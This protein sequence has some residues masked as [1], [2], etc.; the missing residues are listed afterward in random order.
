MLGPQQLTF[1]VDLAE[2]GGKV[3]D[4]TEG[5]ELTRAKDLLGE[6]TLAEKAAFCSGRDFWHLKGIERLG[7]PSIMLTD[8]PHGLRKQTVSG[9]RVDLNA[10]V[11]TTCFPT[12]AALAATWNP[13]L[14]YRV[15]EALAQECLAEKVAI[16][17]GPGANI[18]R[19]PLCG[20]NFEYFSEDPYLTGEM[21]KA[22]IRGVQSKGIG[23]ALKHY[24]A[25]NQES[26]RMSIDAIV[27]ERALREIY[28]TG[29]EIA[30]RG[31]QPATVMCAY[32][33]VNG[34]YCSEH[35]R[36]L[37]EI[38]RDEWG[39]AGV[40]VSDW[41]AVNQRVKGLAAGL[42][43]EM[44]GSRGQND[45]VLLKAVEAGELDEAVLDRAVER[46]LTL[47]LRL[48]G[49]L[50]EDASYDR[51]AHHAL[52]RQVACEAAVL[53]KNEGGI[54]PLGA[55]GPIALIGAFART[56]RYQGAGSSQI[57]PTR[58]ENL[59]DEL[60]KLVGHEQT[61]GFADG[62]RLRGDTIDHAVLGEACR[63]AAQAAVA[64]VCVGLPDCFEVEGVD[65]AHMRLPQ[66]HDALVEAVAGVNPNVVVVLSNGS[67]VELPWADRVKGILEA[68]LGGQA[69]GGAIADI[70]TGRVNPSGKLAETF[71]LHAQ[72][73]PSYA[74]FP[75]GRKTVEYRESVYVGYRYYDSAQRAV[76]FPFG[77]GLSYTKFQYDNLALSAARIADGDR[78]TVEATVTNVGPVAGKETV[79][80]YVRDVEASVFRPDKELKGFLKI[81]L[82]PGEERRVRF[83]LD[84]RAFAFYDTHSAGWRVEPGEFEV[85]VGAS[86]RDIRLFG[87]VEVTSTWQ[88][89]VDPLQRRKLQPYHAPA[90]SFPIARPAFE[91]L[92][93][94]TLPGNDL[95]KRAEHTLNTPIGDM[96]GTIAGRLLY[97]VI[98]RKIDKMIEG[99]NDDEPLSIMMRRMGEELP[100]RGMIMMN[101]ARLTY[102]MLDGVLMMINGRA[103]RG[104]HKL[105]TEFWHTRDSIR[106]SRRKVH[107]RTRSL[108]SDLPSLGRSPSPKRPIWQLGRWDD[109]RPR[110]RQNLH[111]DAPQGRRPTG[112]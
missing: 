25:N 11:P 103:L 76:R 67:P 38:L 94:R 12:A 101:S 31:A 45:A 90:T 36:L 29:F 86:S 66:S 95:A 89:V 91:A 13:D 82:G 100:L 59:C 1:V 4:G 41:G 99:G 65:R 6:M 16:L 42:D 53:L 107:S 70:L 15:G 39:Y 74:S 44:P 50:K 33:R 68:Y 98:Q 8:G 87:A 20:R 85:L 54:L 78:V 55:A 69:G 83:E 51:N 75:G 105:L 84:Q 80:L 37:T 81:S 73:N 19:S 96:S 26:R 112:G 2:R 71:P 109:L 34:T 22:H 93:G 5:W 24:A 52:A 97:K 40:V 77:H 18:K 3:R 110:E 61:V 88:V 7:V 57:K 111:Q 62:Y 92:Y 30:V 17:L 104:M 28:L 21:A 58:L 49:V 106:D 72:D 48:T 10:S 79:Q 60:V 108:G 23:T 35:R 64:I 43:L 46:L 63:V 32:N 102:G 56:P 47:T 27:D 9:E 14:V